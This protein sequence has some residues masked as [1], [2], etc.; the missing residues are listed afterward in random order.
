MNTGLYPVHG[1]GLG[2]RRAFI[3]AAA[4]Q[5]PPE[6][7]FWEIAPENW[8][9]I[10]GGRISTELQTQASEPNPSQLIEAGRSLLDEPDLA[11][12]AEDLRGHR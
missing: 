11:P 4:E 9:A 1:A 5:A 7:S 6:V 12:L 2:L 3:A 10:G 8:I